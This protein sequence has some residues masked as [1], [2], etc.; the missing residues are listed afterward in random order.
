MDFK[1]LLVD[2]VNFSGIIID[3]VLDGIIKVKL[4]EL[5]QKS[6][7]TLD[8][9]LVAMIYP[10]LKKAAEAKLAELISGLVAE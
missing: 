2:N 4:D 9:A 7:N 1:K 5:V 10:E 3:G 6:D 8:D